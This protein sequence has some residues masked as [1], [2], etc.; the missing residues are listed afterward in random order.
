[1][2]V[3]MISLG[4]AKNLIDSEVMLNILKDGKYE[5]TNDPYLADIIIINT[6]GFIE[7]AKQ[8]SINTIIEMGQYK[9]NGKCKLL[10]AAGCLA[11]RYK[12]ELLKE[13]P[14][15]D[16]VI[17][18][19][20]YKSIIEV[21]E[22]S[23]K[24]Q[25]VSLYGHQDKVN[26]DK[27]DRYFSTQGSTAYIKIAEGCDNKC[28]YC[29]IP[30][31]RGRYRSRKF[32]EILAE[33]ELLASKGIKELIVIA[34]D[35]SVYGRDLYNKLML[36]ELLK[37]MAQIN[38]IEWIR[39]LYTYPDEF[40]DDLIR[41]MAN[42]EKICKYVDIPIQHGSNKIL[43]LMGRNT[44][45][46]KILSLINRLRKEIPDI[47]IR[48][49]FIV[50]FPGEDEK[51]F[52]E[53]VEF[54]KKVRFDRMGVFTYSREEDTPAYKLPNQIDEETKLHRHD[55][56]MSVQMDISYGKNLNF[57]GKKLKVLT[58]GYEDG[59]YIGRTY[60]DAPEIDG[61]VYFTSNYEI[62]IGEF[63]DVFITDATDYDLL[64]ECKR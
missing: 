5:I 23:L 37:A 4:C 17:G 36:P 7:K 64:G 18:T 38:G 24:G 11:E 26:I 2:H 45:K 19:G 54:V 6:C 47:T 35:T 29:I 50:G 48:T 13:M 12:D 55:I 52:E 46:E 56:L 60:R 22:K 20:D 1:M 58:E 9:E 8:E 28:T 27:L 15:L 59:Q 32:E 42:E 40:N 16:S 43:K 33:A 21:I 53:L 14:E 41:V 39:L 30:S 51:D 25:K 34:Q 61:L 62:K 3:A 31:L 49:T 63:A 57:I 10:I 44:T